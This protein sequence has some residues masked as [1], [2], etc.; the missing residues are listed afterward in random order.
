MHAMRERPVG[1]ASSLLR[2]LDIQR[3]QSIARREL[4][5]QPVELLVH[6]LGAGPRTLAL[7]MPCSIS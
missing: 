5:E 3:E 6:D 2:H 1:Q 4:L 7:A